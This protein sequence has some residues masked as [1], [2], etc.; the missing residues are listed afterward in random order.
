MLV[1]HCQ[2][3]NMAQKH[4]AVIIS[5]GKPL[6]YGYNHDRMSNRNKMTLS[7]HAEMDVLNKYANLTNTL[8]ARDYLN[9]S[10]R[11]LAVKQKHILK[12]SQVAWI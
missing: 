2:K 8:T 4:A 10:L 6:V 1:P 11:A 9:D 3:S 7:F 5:G 12:G